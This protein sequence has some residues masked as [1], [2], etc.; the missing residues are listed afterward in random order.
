MKRILAL[1]IPKLREIYRDKAG[2]VWNLV[3]PFVMLFVLIQTTGDTESFFKI[4][5]LNHDTGS[6][7]ISVFDSLTKNEKISFDFKK[8]NSLKLGLDQLSAEKLDL[9]INYR[10]QSYWMGDSSEKSKL[11]VYVIQSGKYGY[12][13]DLRV[14]EHPSRNISYAMWVF[15]G[16]VVIN[17]LFSSLF[18][19]GFTISKYRKNGVLKRLYGTPLKKTEF[20]ISQ[21]IVRLLIVTAYILVIYFG[22]ILFFDFK[23]QGSHFNMLILFVSGALCLIIL[24]ILLASLSASEEGGGGIINV[25]LWPMMFLSPIWYSLDNSR[26]VI[27]IISK[28][29]PT[30]YMLDATRGIMLEGTGLQEN[31]FYIGVLLFMALIFLSIT[32]FTFKWK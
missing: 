25:V 22:G 2:F 6:E 28:F 23:I 17:I 32:L 5:E 8:I 19:T 30:T 3:F 15:P 27:Q 4:G 13:K 26:K 29:F 1:V 7:R 24:G 14:M 21:I 10:D 9:V 11:L 20:L 31:L 18:G 16:I 12:Y